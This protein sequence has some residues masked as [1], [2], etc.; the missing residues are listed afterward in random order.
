MIINA[1]KWT[2]QHWCLGKWP[3]LFF[4][5]FSDPCSTYQYC[6]LFKPNANLVYQMYIRWRGFFFQS[7]LPKQSKLHPEEIEDYYSSWYNIFLG[8]NSLLV[9]ASWEGNVPC[10]AAFWLAF[11]SAN[12]V[13][14][15]WSAV[16]MVKT[17]R[18]LQRNCLLFLAFL[19]ACLATSKLICDIETFIY[20]SKTFGNYW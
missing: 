12:H 19:N 14:V 4:G 9:I 15:P 17:N 20:I 3:H 5:W 13:D 1:H 2:Q 11:P 7:Q 16:A 18:M 6:Y 8:A 10:I